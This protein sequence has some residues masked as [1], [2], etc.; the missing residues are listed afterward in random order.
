M[1]FTKETLRKALRT[2]I[3]AFVAY[4]IV[5]LPNVD[6]TVEDSVLKST[7]LGLC[8]SAIAAGLAAVMN[9]EKPE[10]L[11]GNSTL[12][13][14]EWVKKYIGKKTDYDGVY[15]VQCVDLIDCYIDKVLGLKKGFWGNARFWWTNRNTSKWLKDNFKFVTPTYKNGELKKG[16]IGIRTSGTYGHIFVIAEPTAKGK[17]KYYDQN[18]DGKG[19]AMTLREKPYT[20]QY[21]NGVL[22]PKDQ[23]KIATPPTIKKGTYTLTNV[24]G[25][26]KG[27]GAP[28]GRK[29]VKELTADGKKCATSTNDSSDAYLKAGTKVTI[30]ATKLLPSGNLWAKI[31]S[32]YICI[33]ECDADKLFV[34]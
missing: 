2:F 34:K 7:M 27:Y 1:K 14:A 4:L 32:G 17:I 3:Q 26:Y 33:W 25:V 22:R 20:A 6:F 12:S 28:T 21:I 19:A 24:R 18:A 10:Q 9:L 16:D 13:F 31:P 11:G 15:G 30:S 29:K 8:A 23:S 5:A